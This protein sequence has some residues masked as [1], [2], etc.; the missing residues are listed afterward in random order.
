MHQFT[1]SPDIL[2]YSSEYYL[3]FCIP[4][5][6]YFVFEKRSLSRKG[7]GSFFTSRFAGGSFLDFERSKGGSFFKKS[8]FFALFCS[9]SPKKSDIRDRHL[10]GHHIIAFKICFVT[11]HHFFKKIFSS[12]G[13]GHF[14]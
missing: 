8:S 2:R 14:L 5:R 12:K 13:G 6:K 10:T 3:V 11:I 1:D 4:Y 9:E 7:G